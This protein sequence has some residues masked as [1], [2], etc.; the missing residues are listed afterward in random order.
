MEALRT[1][2]LSVVAI[3]SVMKSSTEEVSLRNYGSYYPT[4]TPG[5]PDVDPPELIGI[6][7]DVNYDIS[8]RES[9]ERKL[10]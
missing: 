3:A 9:G 5:N 7:K 10:N 2:K 8:S 6:W 1:I 4:G